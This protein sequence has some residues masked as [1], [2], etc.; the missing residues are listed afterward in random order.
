MS[1]RKQP[2]ESL[3]AHAVQQLGLARGLNWTLDEAGAIRDQLVSTHEALLLAEAR[4]DVTA[5]EPAS[6]FDPG[7]ES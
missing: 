1:D 6:A 7:R 4:I 5:E 3:D 2:A